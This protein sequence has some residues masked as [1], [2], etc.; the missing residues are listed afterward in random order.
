MILL[1][2]PTGNRNVRAVLAGLEQAEKLALFQTTLAVEKSDWYIRLIPQSVRQELLRRAYNIPGAKISKRPLKELLRLSASKFGAS[3]LTTHETGWASIDSVYRDLD[4]YTA[5]QLTNSWRDC[6]VSAVYCYEDAAIHT[7]YAAKQLGL[8]CFY[9]LPIGYWRAGKIIQQEESE[10]NPEWAATLTAN[11]DSVEKLVRKDEELQLADV[12]FVASSF[13][14]QT[15]KMAPKVCPPIVV[16][17]Y[18]APPVTRSLRQEKSQG[19]LLCCIEVE[20]S[21]N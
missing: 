4:L 21:V 15:L 13:T 19:K 6:Q 10:L 20:V 9:D 11:F 2:H 18:G 3:F 14:Q 1:S 17:P 16:I 8:K 5:E 7:F 12:V